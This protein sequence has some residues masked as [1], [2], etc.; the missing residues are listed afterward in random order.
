MT[1]QSVLGYIFRKMPH[2]YI[3]SPG[4]VVVQH[5]YSFAY[6]TAYMTINMRIHALFGRYQNVNTKY[7]TS[8][9]RD[10]GFTDETT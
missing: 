7:M 3:D 8:E 5:K 10:R 6:C 4:L 9:T 2:Y 1:D